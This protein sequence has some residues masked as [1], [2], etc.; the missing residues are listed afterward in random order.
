MNEIDWN[1]VF[2]YLIPIIVVFIAGLI[3]LYRMRENVKLD[4]K[5]HRK[6]E[7]R[8]A[9]KETNKNI[10]RLLMLLAKERVLTGDDLINFYTNELAGLVAE[11]ESSIYD[12][13]II[14]NKDNDSRNSA[15]LE[16]NKLP[17]EIVK[18]DEEKID[19]KTI[20]TIQNKANIH[21][22]QYYNNI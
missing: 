3:A 7:L 17:N 14:M 16:L 2:E 11:I 1:K 13:R 21:L 8:K 9:I 20:T 22:R 12:L 5:N 10:T 15:L 18:N 4:E 6:E 19:V